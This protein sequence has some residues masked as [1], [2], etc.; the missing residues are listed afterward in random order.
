VG[1]VLDRLHERKRFRGQGKQFEPDDLFQDVG[2]GFAPPP[3]S[4]ESVHEDFLEAPAKSA[5]QQVSMTIR[6]SVATDMLR[7]ASELS[8]FEFL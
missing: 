4:T 1:P 2:C 7:G 8:H 6:F 3:F 5:E